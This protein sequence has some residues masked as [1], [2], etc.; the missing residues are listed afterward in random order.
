MVICFIS[1]F[2]YF[3]PFS[4]PLVNDC[5]HDAANVTYLRVLMVKDDGDDDEEECKMLMSNTHQNVHSTT[6]I[7]SFSS[8]YTILFV[9]LLN[10]ED[11]HDKC[12]TNGCEKYTKIWVRK[13]MLMTNI[14]FNSKGKLS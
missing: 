2:V 5:C 7:R 6:I 8:S 10:F 4:Y 13:F 1:L 3:F 14:D 9:N 12:S 11:T